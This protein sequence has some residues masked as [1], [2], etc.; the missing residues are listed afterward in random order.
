MNEAMA[1]A[2]EVVEAIHAL[3][4]SVMEILCTFNFSRRTPMPK[5]ERMRI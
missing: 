5:V 4:G 2:A 3:Y 1:T